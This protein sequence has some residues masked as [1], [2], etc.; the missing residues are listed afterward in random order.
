M[1]VMNRRRQLAKAGAL[2]NRIL[3]FFVCPRQSHYR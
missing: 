1:F 2:A 3:F